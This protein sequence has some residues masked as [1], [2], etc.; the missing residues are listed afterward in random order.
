M[1]EY[2]KS[3]K[4]VMDCT[5][6]SQDSETHFGRMIDFC[7]I[8]HYCVNCSEGTGNNMLQAFYVLELE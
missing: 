7:P 6:I 3:Q 2:N 4:V 1:N 5:Y 8:G